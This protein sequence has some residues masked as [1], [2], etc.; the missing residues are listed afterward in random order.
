MHCPVEPGLHFLPLTQYVSSKI[1]P[2]NLIPATKA[3]VRNA[4]V[5]VAPSKFAP[6]RLTPC[7]F[8]PLKSSFFRYAPTLL[9]PRQST[10]VIA[11]SSHFAKAS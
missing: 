4:E 6:S 1:A 5:I 10:S 7:R 3:L 8:A 2:F 11:G 9:N